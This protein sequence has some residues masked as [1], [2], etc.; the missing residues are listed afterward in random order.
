MSIYV[1]IFIRGDME[2]LWTR[3]QDPKLHQLWDLRF[4]EIDYLPRMAG[5][6][7]KFTYATRI[8]AGLRIEGSGESTGEHN[9]SNGQ[10]TS[11]LKFWSEDAKSLIEVG[12]GY[13][14]YIPVDDGIRFITWYDYRTRWGTLGRII[15]KVFFRPL[16][17]WAT[18]WSFDGL[19]LWI[20]KDIPPEIS[21]QKTFA[22][23]LSRLSIAFVWIYHGLLPKL[24]YRNADEIRMLHESGIANP[25]IPQ[26]LSILGVLEICMGLSILIFWKSRRVLWSTILLMV[27]AT[28]S[29]AVNSPRYLAG[30]FNPI[31]LNLSVATLASIGLI[32]GISIPTADN[33]MRKPPKEDR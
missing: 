12:S 18:A 16:L 29:V 19:R 11:A 30:A 6:P 10:R 5:E 22:H 14:K 17:G 28:L 20:E 9:D 4:S 21:L 26:A 31:T 7:Q 33:C 8:G 23:V 1:E 2:E 32:T 13:W 25:Y 24:I 27:L 15:D 3:T